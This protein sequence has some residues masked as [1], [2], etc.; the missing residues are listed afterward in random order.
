[1]QVLELLP[2]DDQTR[3]ALV[4]NLAASIYKQG[5]QAN[6]AR[7]LS[8]RGRPLPA[9]GSD[10]A[11]LENQGDRRIRCRRGLIQLKDWEHGGTVL[12]GFRNLSP[13]MSCS[14]K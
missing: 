8:G 5:E 13:A 7:G 4:D 11:D 6:A 14:P 12:T 1:V 2:A 10:G 9:G 3:D